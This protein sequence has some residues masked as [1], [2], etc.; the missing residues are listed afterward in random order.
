MG[1][2]DEVYNF[3]EFKGKSSYVFKSWLLFSQV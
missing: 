2:K 3:M 1:E